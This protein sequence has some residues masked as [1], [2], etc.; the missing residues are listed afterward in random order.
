MRD[1]YSLYEAK[2]KF[3]AIVRQ[4]REG[5]RIL[6]TVHGKPVAEIRP[7]QGDDG[8]IEAR[9]ERLVARGIVIRPERRSARLG[10]VVRRP[11]ALGRFLRD[12]DG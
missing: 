3:S 1:T 4:V 2:T 12:R 5:R 8:G 6:V 10:P 11:G 7:V 9:L